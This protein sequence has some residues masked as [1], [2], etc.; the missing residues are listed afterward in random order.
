MTIANKKLGILF[1]ILSALSFAL[2]AVFVR[3]AGDLPTM[4]K[5][6]FRNI[7]ALVV[8]TVMIFKEKTKLSVPRGSGGYVLMRAIFG[9]AAVACNFYAIGKINLAD[10][11]M[12][13][14]ISPFFAV[15]FSAMLLS[16]KIPPKKMFIILGAFAGSLLIIKPSPANLDMGPSMI[17][18][19][20]GVFTGVSYTCLRGATNNGASKPSIVFWF[21]AVSTIALLPIAVVQFVMPTRLQLI[22]LLLCGVFS[23]AGQFAVTAA[24]AH[25]PARD[26]AIYGY[27]QILFSAPLGLLLF[28][29][30]PDF[31]SFIGYIVIIFFAWL[32]YRES[33]IH[34]DDTN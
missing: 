30:M 11:N 14:K 27:T 25:A 28:D 2:M 1:S 31:L 23:A 21:S 12:L 17:A 6:L 10:A 29:Q 13:N 24:Y 8:S 33:H 18:A 19:L 15:I 3:L 20:G 4:E 9:T 22:Y 5:A 16:E 26:I 34:I 32:D 7:I